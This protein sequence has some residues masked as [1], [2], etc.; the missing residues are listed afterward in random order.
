MVRPDS[1]LP[2]RIWRNE[3]FRRSFPGF[4]ILTIDPT[5]PG[6]K[7]RLIELKSSGVNARVQSMTWNEWK[8]A[9]DSTLRQRFFLYL[10]SNL[11]SDLGDTAPYLRA[12]RDPFGSLWNQEV[13]E[14]SVKRT[15][16]LNVS[17]FDTAEELTLQVRV[18][19]ETN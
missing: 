11:R 13:H 9:R 7:D 14:S 10:V 2:W 12:I 16:Q 5:N 8:T 15:I 19:D 17:E 3:E 18:P 4:D 6:T 1:A